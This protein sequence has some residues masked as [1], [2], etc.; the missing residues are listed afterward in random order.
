M[1]TGV[2]FLLT[3]T[4]P[5]ECDHCFLHCG[6]YAEGTFTISQVRRTLEEAQKLGTVTSIYFE[7]GE[8]FLYY[9]LLVE[10]VR[11]AK[12]MGFR[13]GIVSNGYWATSEED[14]QL[15]LKPLAEIGLDDL[16]LSDDEYHRGSA[17]VSP[18][19]AARAAAESLGMEPSTICIDAP[20]VTT[21]EAADGTKGEPVIG[22]GAVFRGRAAEKLTTGLPTRS[23][24][25]MT[26]CPHEELKAPKRVHVD[27]FGNVHICQGLSMGNMWQT[28]LS[29]LVAHYDYRE[30]PICSALVEGGPSALARGHNVQAADRYVDEC[31]M[32]YLVRKELLNEHPQFLAPPQ[33]YGIR[34]GNDRTS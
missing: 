19:Q 1:L 18:V 20:V 2:H 5:F 9:P 33:V 32:C 6:P 28:P 31:H 34:P 17:Q 30:H 13:I 23:A 26:C 14:A 3:Y 4:C 29:E 7:G 15:W 16:S 10:S 25:T 8:A 24:R 11:L 27:S 22:G 12:K 21:P